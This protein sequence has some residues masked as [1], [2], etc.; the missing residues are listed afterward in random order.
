MNAKY[1]IHVVKCFFLGV[2]MLVLW[3][4]ALLSVPILLICAIGESFLESCHFKT[5]TGTQEKQND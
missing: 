1:I 2:V 4:L 3:P 5:R